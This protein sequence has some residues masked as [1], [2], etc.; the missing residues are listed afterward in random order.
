[1]GFPTYPITDRQK[2]LVALAGELADSFAQR[3]AAHEWEG[4]FPYEN[5][6]DLRQSGYLALTVPRDFG[7]MGVDLLEAILAQQRLAQG[8]ASTALVMSMHLHNIARLAV[9]VSGHNALFEKLCN[10]VIQEGAII[11]T[12]ASEPATGSPSRGG[13]FST[14]ARQQA[15]GSWVV[16]GHKIYTT[17]S[18]IVT[19]FLVNCTLEAAEGK[20][21]S[22]NRGN[23]L[24]PHA[25]PG[26]RVA[27]TWNSA[28]MRASGSHD[29]I[30]ENVHVPANAYVEGQIPTNPAAQSKMQAWQLITTAVYH[31]IAEAARNEAIRFARQRRPNTLNKPIASVPHIQEK[32]AH[33][34]LKLIQSRSILYGL[35]AQFSANPDSIEASDCA[36]AKYIVTN[37]A[38]EVVDIA[39]RLVGAASLSLNSPLQRYYRD[40]RAG[41]SNPPA[42]DVTIAMLSKQALEG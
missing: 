11:N 23:I 31:G 10:A 41:L 38:V 19:Y 32:A 9:N 36:A 14:T 18:P 5:Y 25:A 4:S 37:T 30:L 27:E 2:K 8:D 26:V 16:N 17:G 12:A 40:V 42:D 1:M 15:D 39:M 29:L 33:I 7:G 28:A 22:S 20:E 21:L 6:Q 13:R 3:A 24:V 34:E 35:A